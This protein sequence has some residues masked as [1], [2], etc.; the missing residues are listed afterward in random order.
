MGGVALLA[1]ESDFVQVENAKVVGTNV[2]SCEL[3]LNSKARFFVV[4]CY[5][6]PSDT[7]GRAQKLVEQALRDKPE[8][9]MPLVIGDLN[10]NLDAPRSR[11]EEVLSQL[12]AGEGLGCATRHFQ[13]RRRKHVRGRWTFRREQLKAS[14]LT[15]RSPMTRGMEP[16]GLSRRACST[17]FCARPKVSD[18]AR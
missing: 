4:G 2:L 15:F 3:V 11:R 1:R 10:A 6:A 7:L 17:S 9:S 13:V 12:L 8:G 18:G 14:R 5:L 16:S